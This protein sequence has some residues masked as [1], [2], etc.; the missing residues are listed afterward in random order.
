FLKPN[1]SVL[2]VVI[3]KIMYIRTN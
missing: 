3:Y 2:I 1:K